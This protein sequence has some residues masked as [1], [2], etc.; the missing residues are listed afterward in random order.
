MIS[1]IT[2]VSNYSATYQASSL[3]REIKKKSSVD[4]VK[5][6]QIHVLFLVGSHT[7]NK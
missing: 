6:E 1:M 2:P 5:R 3:P 4:K 7:I